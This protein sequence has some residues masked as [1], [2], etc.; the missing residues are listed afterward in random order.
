MLLI[1]DRNGM[2][3]LDRLVNELRLSDQL[4]FFAIN[5]VLSKLNF[6]NLCWYF[7]IKFDT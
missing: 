7:N 5:L 4:V 2:A 3:S 6:P 1:G